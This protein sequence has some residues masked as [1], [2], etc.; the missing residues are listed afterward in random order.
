MENHLNLISKKIFNQDDDY[1]SIINSWKKQNNTIIFTNGCFDILH[2]GHIEYLAKAA[3]LGNKLIIGLNRDSSVKKLKGE[4]RPVQ[5]EKSRALIL[6]TISFIDMIIYFE[7]ETPLNLIQNI[8]PDVLVKGGDYQI[9][10]IVGSH[11]VAKQG[12]RVLTIPFIEGYSS[13]KII[14][15]I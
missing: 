6:S 1:I 10:N 12:G 8:C 3:D 7:E 13:T 2:R 14:D 11:F 5:D 15:S 4:K 9:E